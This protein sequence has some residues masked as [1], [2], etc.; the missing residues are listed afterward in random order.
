[1]C[2]RIDFD[3]DFKVLTALKGWVGYAPQ[4]RGAL[5][6]IIITKNCVIRLKTLFIVKKFSIPAYF[7]FSLQFPYRSVTQPTLQYNCGA[8]QARRK[9][10][11][12]ETPIENKTHLQ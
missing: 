1:M 11:T 9:P 2:P 5:H 12:K 6:I 7:T 8:G 10:T 3:F 4:G